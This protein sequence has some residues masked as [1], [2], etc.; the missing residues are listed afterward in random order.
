[1]HQ[2]IGNAIHIPLRIVNGSTTDAYKHLK[3]PTGLRAEISADVAALKKKSEE[4][5]VV[6]R[7]S[8]QKQ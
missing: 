8:Q 6:L 7:S 3:L 1:M 2:C 5:M 4:M